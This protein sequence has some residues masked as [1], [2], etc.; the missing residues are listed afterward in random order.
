MTDKQLFTPGPL[1]TSRTVK[2]AMLRDVGSR[3]AEFIETV[4]D[5]RRRLLGLASVDPGAFTT[6]LMQGS[7]TFAIES[8]VGSALPRDRRLLVLANGA[9][10]ERIARIAAVLGI[11]HEVMRFPEYRTPEPTDVDTVLARDSAITL[12]AYVHCET[13][14][15]ILNPI[16]TIGAVVRKHGR[17]SFVDAMSSFG[18]VSDRLRGRRY[19]LSGVVCQ[20]V[21]RGRARFRLRYCKARPSSCSGAMYWNVPR[22]APCSVSGCACVGRAERPVSDGATGSSVSFARPKSR[23]FALSVSMTLPGFR[24]RWVTPCR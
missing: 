15:G 9:Y 13:T 23:S 12:V 18:A 7:G 1:S 22:M 24:S 6:V 10:G 5:I 11:D 16:E 3:D 20:Q 2:D 21:H 8:V 17:C 4:R 14:S 19:R